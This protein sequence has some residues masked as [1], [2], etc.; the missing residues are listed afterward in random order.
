[1]EPGRAAS[2]GAA[3]SA[4]CRPYR[5]TT[6][7]PHAAVRISMRY[8][9]SSGG[10]LRCCAD[11]VRCGALCV[12]CAAGERGRERHRCRWDGIAAGRWRHYCRGRRHCCLAA[13]LPGEVCVL[14]TECACVLAGS[15]CLPG[16]RWR[17]GWGVN[18]VGMGQGWD[19]DRDGDRDRERERE[20]ITARRACACWCCY[21][22]CVVQTA[23]SL[24][25]SCIHIC[26]HFRAAR[27]ACAHGEHGTE[28]REG[29]ESE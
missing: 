11:C 17:V 3:S 27:R 26:R 8:R 7:T 25:H 20:R 19:G 15:V 10:Y 23:S 5:H 21:R 12:R 2:R 1:M 6:A 9:L 18:G 4:P 29:E 22:Q 24:A 16:S 14:L 28:R 13:S